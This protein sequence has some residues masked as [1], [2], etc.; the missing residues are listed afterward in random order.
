MSFWGIA[1]ATLALWGCGDFTEPKCAQEDYVRL[2]FGDDI[3]TLSDPMAQLKSLDVGTDKR[4][5]SPESASTQIHRTG[6]RPHGAVRFFSYCQEKGTPPVKVRAFS[7]H[8]PRVKRHPDEFETTLIEFRYPNNISDN[9]K[10]RWNSL[11]Y[12]SIKTIE[13]EKITL[14]SGIIKNKDSKLIIRDKKNS[15]F[16][17]HI[18]CIGTFKNDQEENTFRLFFPYSKNTYL[19]MQMHH[20][21]LVDADATLESDIMNALRYVENMK[22]TE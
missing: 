17:L 8:I 4:D 22:I 15:I 16:K 14:S 20:V 10:T 12:K 1:I 21:R 19:F 11:K 13:L 3:Y 7:M 9:L 18:T 5:M 2:Q 6:V